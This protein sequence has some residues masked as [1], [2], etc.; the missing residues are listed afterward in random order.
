M[1]IEV[2]S[3][4]HF[5]NYAKIK[6]NIEECVAKFDEVKHESDTFLTLF[7]VLS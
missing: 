1:D 3:F 5:K 4:Q 2:I 7:C 6:I